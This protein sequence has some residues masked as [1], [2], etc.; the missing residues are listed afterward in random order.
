MSL[1]R[2]NW[3]VLLKGHLLDFLL[4][5]PIFLLTF[6]AF[7]FDLYINIYTCMH[8]IS[9]NIYRSLNPI[10]FS[11]SKGGESNKNLLTF[12]QNGLPYTI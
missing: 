2:I 11:D 5:K 10:Y 6:M 4:L 7:L 9:Q 3:L 12:S 1:I 8:L